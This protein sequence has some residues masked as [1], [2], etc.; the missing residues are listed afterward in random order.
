MTY[1]KIP[2][3]NGCGITIPCFGNPGD[4]R[5]SRCEACKNPGMINIV[6]RMC[7]VCGKHQPCFGMIGDKQP[8][9]CEACKEP[10]MLNIKDHKCITCGKHQPFFGMPDDLRSTRCKKC[11]E[12]GMIDIRNRMCA[13]CGVT[14]PTFGMPEDFR[15]SRCEACKLRGMIDIANR[16]C[17]VCGK[18]QPCFGM[19]EDKRATRCENCKSPD[20]VDLIHRTCIREG[21]MT[22]PS[23]PWTPY[24][25]GCYAELH[26][27]DP[28]VKA[29]F[30]T[31]TKIKAF[32]NESLDAGISSLSTFNAMNV[33]GNR[34][35]AWLGNH[36]EIDFL[37]MGERGIIHCDGGQHKR[38]V[39]FFSVNTAAVQI[40][41]DVKNS[42]NALSNG[43]FE[44]RID[45]EDVWGDRC[46]WRKLLTG[47]LGFGI[48]R[49]LAGEATCVVG[50]RDEA[51]LSYGPYVDAMLQ[52]PHA[53]RVYEAFLTP[54]ERDM[55]TVIH[56][57]S[58]ARTH[59]RI[60]SEFTLARWPD[61]DAA[62]AAPTAPTQ[63]TLEA[64]FKRRK[65]GAAPA[66]GLGQ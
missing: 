2:K 36:D 30:K 31:E 55:L 12:P 26:P 62:P 50:R 40:A 60:P 19:T 15:P 63:L 14:R 8:S 61:V 10:G 22:R 37:I 5:P 18:H 17:D 53:E 35:P 51:D 43:K 39:A 1:V 46:D 49:K 28:L 33:R 64:A 65:V 57:A 16:S 13:A 25:A 24:C 9:R 44:V 23:P 54:D 42:V 48:T 41:R 6:S 47:M 11:K 56:R 66:A 38:D 34:A 3:C 21:C 4:K 59:W 7:D 58:G 32:L 20:M 29:R 52:T 27:D 45:Q